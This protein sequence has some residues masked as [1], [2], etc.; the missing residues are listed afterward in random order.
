MIYRT[1][2][3]EF[4]YLILLCFAFLCLQVSTAYAQC[5]FTPKTNCAGDACSTNPTQFTYTGPTN[6]GDVFAWDFGDQQVQ[7]DTSSQQNPQYLYTRPGTYTVTLSINGTANCT[8]TVTIGGFNEFTLDPDINKG[9][10]EEEICK[11]ELEAGVTLTTKFATGGAPPNATYLWST[12]ATTPTI[13]IDTAGCYSVQITDPATGC[14]RTNKVTVTSYKPDPNAPQEPQER[15]RW[16]F[17]NGAGIKFVGGQPEAV[18]GGQVNVPEGSSTVSNAGG[19]LL[20]YTDGKNI[21]RPDGTVMP[22]GDNLNGGTNI[23]QGVLIVSQP[24][25]ASCNSVYYVFTISDTG[26]LQYSIVDMRGDAGKGTV[27]PGQKNLPLFPTSTE[28]VTAVAAEPDS[29]T[30][31]QKTWIITHDANA[32][33]FRVYPLDA[34][35]IGSPVTSDSGAVHGPEPIKGEGYMKVSPDG[36]KVAV[37]IPGVAPDTTNRLQ[38]FDFDTKTGKLSNPK[39]IDLGPTPPSAYGLEFASDTTLYV[40]LTGDGTTQSQL[41]QFSVRS[42]DTISISNSRKVIATSPQ[43]YG[44]LQIDPDKQK[45]YLAIEGSGSVGVINQPNDTLNVDFQENGFNLGGPTSQLGLPNISPTETPPGFGQGFNFDG[46]ECAA[47]GEQVTYEFQASPDR[48]PRNDGQPNSF[49]EWRFPDG[50]TSNAQN[51]SH[52][53]PGPGTYRVTLNIWND[54]IPQPG[55][56][57]EKT[58]TIRRAPDPF[59]IAPNA[60]NQRQ[61]NNISTCQPNVVLD[62]QANVPGSTY[63]WSLNGAPIAGA[64]NRTLTVTQSGLYTVLLANGSCGRADQVNVTFTRPQVDLG[65][66]TTLCGGGDQ[67]VLNAG[68]PGST[69]LWST[70][71]TTQTIT[72]TAAP[73]SSTTYSVTVTQPGPAGCSDTDEIVVRGGAPSI[74]TATSTP[75]AADCSGAGV[76]TGTVTLTLPGTGGPFTYA[77]TGPGGFTAT[78]QNLTGLAAGTYQATIVNAAGCQTIVQASV[79]SAVTTLAYTSNAPVTAACATTPTGTISLTPGAAPSTVASSF[80]WRNSNGQV[81]PGQTGPTLT[82]APGTYSVEL[83]DAAS[84]KQ[85][86]SNLVILPDNSQPIVTASAPVITGCT[87][88]E[89]YASATGGNYYVWRKITNNNVIAPATIIAQGN[90]ASS[91]TNPPV[92]QNTAVERYTVSVYVDQT[93]FTTGSPCFGVDTVTVTFPPAP[94]ATIAAGP[95]VACEGQTITLTAN[96]PPAGVTYR[97]QWQRVEFN[98]ATDIPGEQG[99]TLTVTTSGNY[100]VSITVPQS[101]CPPAIDTR[102]VTFNAVPVADFETPGPIS[103]CRGDATVLRA[104]VP[105]GTSYTYRWAIKGSNTSLPAGAIISVTPLS[106][107]IYVLTVT[108]GNCVSASK[109]ITVTVTPQPFVDFTNTPNVFCEGGSVVLNAIN[110]GAATYV[111]SRNGQVIP[112]QSGATY[113]ATQSGEYSVTVTIGQCSTTATHNINPPLQL[114]TPSVPRKLVEFCFKEDPGILADVVVI[115]DNSTAEWYNLD[116]PTVKIWEGDTLPAG[117]G[118]YVVKFINN[119]GCSAFDTINVVDKCE[120]RLFI[121]DAFTPNGDGNNDEFVVRH[122]GYIKNLEVRIYNRW[123]EVV[124]VSRIENPNAD[125]DGSLLIWDGTFKGQPSPVGSYVWT[126]SYE[127]TDYP[128]R[129]PVKLRGGVA[130]I[131]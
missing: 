11:E 49:F 85:F 82:A 71:A 58:I 4:Q 124:T 62:A 94:T 14:S 50:S 22:G 60:P 104:V 54:C 38:I 48:A 86:L 117:P 42:D 69:Y 39:N 40:S 15:G 64:T 77:W 131:R 67:I 57:F 13:Q 66:D 3:K 96:Q 123:G 112:G 119:E 33:T 51:P 32:N 2:N 128:E 36:S 89:L 99:R 120:P 100:R 43:K 73:G 114:P 56:F 126:V 45:I 34:K 17:G 111:W 105:A 27:T 92:T 87:T 83:T 1:R 107:T 84:C 97:Y 101:N 88:A 75:T 9:P 129:A 118:S 30:G 29:V 31:A 70:G 46:P 68:N 63:Q 20:F 35:G 8:Q 21:Y 115:T 19:Q 12:G 28:R 47:L 7:T 25:C 44:A 23:T 74:I 103:V 78:T 93:A 53:F 80:V 55:E 102:T 125:N 116:N 95:N 24:G 37:I 76:N 65:P 41:L 130:L 121:P 113:T 90:N 5:D 109:E 79:N 122:P 10:Q 18:T 91:V 72:V 61:G 98:V 6:P 106:T 16:Y 26:E 108:N 59:R 52:T 110:P 81:I 127:S